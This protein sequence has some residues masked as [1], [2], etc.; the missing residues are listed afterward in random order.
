[1]KLSNIHC[2]IWEERSSKTKYLYWLNVVRISF[3]MI[4]NNVMFPYRII[5]STFIFV[6]TG[7]I[8][9]SITQRLHRY[10]RHVCEIITIVKTLAQYSWIAWCTMYNCTYIAWLSLCFTLETS[11]VALFSVCEWVCQASV[12]PDQIST[13]SNIYRHTSPLLT[14][15]HLISSSTNLYWPSTSQYRHILTQYHQVPLMIDSPV[16]HS[17]ANWIISLFTAHLM[18]HAQYKILGLVVMLIW[19]RIVLKMV[20]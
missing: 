15:Y 11:W 14:M 6:N 13:F 18:S 5:K 8:Q 9:D 4:T 1:M 20:K 16:W 19:C 7:T 2:Q 17:S 12:T 10:W 3:W